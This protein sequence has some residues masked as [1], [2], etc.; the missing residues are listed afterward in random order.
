M[1]V[2]S[3]PTATRALQNGE[4][5]LYY[6]E[7]KLCNDWDLSKL[8]VP[9]E[10]LNYGNVQDGTLTAYLQTFLA[11]DAESIGINTEALYS[12]LTQT[13]PIV[14]VCFERMQV[15]YHRGALTTINPTQDNIFD[16]MYN[17]KVTL[18]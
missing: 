9:G 17:W 16:D 11:S 8:L 5:D 14:A 18:S 13:A 12:Y 15:L 7:V 2:I 10:A 3:R 1:R 6:G 4:Y